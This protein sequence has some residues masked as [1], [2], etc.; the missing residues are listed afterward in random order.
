MA[1]DSAALAYH[2]PGIVTI[3]V[4]SSFLVTSGK[5]QIK[6][7]E[8]KQDSAVSLSRAE[9]AIGIANASSSCNSQD[10][11]R[12]VGV[13]NYNHLTGV[14]IFEK[15]YGPPLHGI[16][17]PFF[18]ASI[19]FAIPI[20][21]MF[22]G[23]V[24]WRGI[25]Y[26]ILMIAAKLFCGLCLVRFTSLVIPARSIRKILPTNFSTHLPWPIRTKPVA[27][28]RDQPAQA[29]TVAAAVP[30]I[31]Q[32]KMS[33]PKPISLYPATMLGSAMVAR[34][35]MG[36]LISSVAE[37]Q[38]VFGSSA[39]GGSSEL[40]LIVTWAILICTLLGPIVVG[41]M[42][43]RVKRLQAMER[44]K[45]TGREDPLGIW[46]MQSKKSNNETVGGTTGPP[47]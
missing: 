11:S 34:G 18:F 13:T 4:L 1:S 10:M 39:D 28:S 44:S 14:H 37:S 6:D 24:I 47:T 46:G 31:T 32:R 29:S 16:L 38:G 41:L 26:T 15:Y 3:L 8:Q 20:T 30:P 45:S 19:G 27:T 43:K 23:A 36:F 33:I 40:Y 9:H 7:S 21:Q 22:G 12:K 42:V 25:V 17:K 35:E 2:E 5:R